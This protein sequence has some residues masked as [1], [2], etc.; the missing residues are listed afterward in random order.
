MKIINIILG[1]C[2]LAVCIIGGFFFLIGGFFLLI[3]FFEGYKAIN[4]EDIAIFILYFILVLAIVSFSVW[5]I[6]EN[7]KEGEF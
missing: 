5:Y 2:L 7:I 6:K 4:I 1:F 3:M